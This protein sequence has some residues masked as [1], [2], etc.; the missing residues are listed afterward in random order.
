MGTHEAAVAVGG[1]V[2]WTEAHAELSR[3]AQERA[4]LDAEEA[5]WLLRAL[6]S[7]AHEHYGFGSFYQ[8]VEWLFG[9]RPRTTQDKLRVAE[10]LEGLP[11]LNGALVS[12]VL[13]WSAVRELTRVAVPETEHAWLEAARGKTQREIEALVADKAVGDAPDAPGTGAHRHV[14]RFEVDAD[15]FA[16]FREAMQRL[17]RAAGGRSSHDALLLAMARHVLGGPGDHGRSSYQISLRV[18]S[19]CRRGEQVASGELIAVEPAVVEMAECDAQHLGELPTLVLTGR[20]ANGN[21]DAPHVSEPAAAASSIEALHGGGGAGAGDE[22]A[23]RRCSNHAPGGA[24]ESRVQGDV[25]SAPATP[26]TPATAR[27]SLPRARQ[28]IP[29]ALRRAVLERDQHRCQVPGCTHTHYVDVHHIQRRADGGLNAIWN[30]ITLCSAHHRAAHRGELHIERGSEGVLTFRHADG[31]VYGALPPPGRVDLFAKVFSALRQLGFRELEVK[32]VLA[33]L[34]A[35]AALAQA[36]VERL[37][38]EALCRIKHTP[39]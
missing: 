7:G 38:R 15:T 19:T 10:A 22:D 14:L 37:L 34:R 16:T 35:D 26:A 36:T 25:P 1:T 5:P 11:A 21:A 27:R 13:R 30:L 12:G 28:T 6:R 9:Y 18:C 31:S 2:H 23:A 8:Y 4:R 24:I 20:A 33:E 32:A 39:R 17:E 29:P 3:L